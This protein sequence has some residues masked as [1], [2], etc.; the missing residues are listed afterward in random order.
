MALCV[1]G[2]QAQGQKEAKKHLAGTRLTQRQA[3]QAKCYD[4]M[5]GY[6]DGKRSCKIPDCPLSPYMPYRD[7]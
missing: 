6:V 4:C 3:I 1:D 2:K 7:A 5:G